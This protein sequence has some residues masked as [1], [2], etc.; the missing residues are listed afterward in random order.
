MN[1]LLLKEPQA[2]A[3]LWNCQHREGCRQSQASPALPGCWITWCCPELL[4]PGGSDAPHPH[5]SAAHRNWTQ[6]KLPASGSS[7]CRNRDAT[8]WVATI[9]AHTLQAIGG[10]N[11]ASLPSNL[12][13][14]ASLL[15]FPICFINRHKYI[16]WH[17]N[18][19]ILGRVCFNSSGI[20]HI[21]SKTRPIFQF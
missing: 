15:F 3:G 10:K 20:F 21:P 13:F 1:W 19:L 16:Y 18:V 8:L 14:Y 2:W 17:P 5:P 12:F 4:L 6:Q 7:A 9:R 11:R